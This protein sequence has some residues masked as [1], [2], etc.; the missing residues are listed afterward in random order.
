VTVIECIAVAA[1]I[2]VDEH[3]HVLLTERIGDSPFAGLWEFPGG[4][5]AAGESAVA[6]M[7]RELAEELG[8][9]VQRSDPFMNVRHEYADRA[10]ALEFFLVTQ[11][12]GD[13]VGLDGQALQWRKPQNIQVE[14]LLPA[15]APVLRALQQAASV[16][17]LS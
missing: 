12:Q 6:A 2:L 15:D 9:R 1:G 3:G 11:W 8:I 14:E 4:K 17:E 16:S 5:I 7:R 10:V 13:P